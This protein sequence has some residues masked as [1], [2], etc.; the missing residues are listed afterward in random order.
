MEKVNLPS[1]G[2]IYL[3]L[4]FKQTGIMTKAI[5]QR[6]EEKVV[7]SERLTDE[8]AL[9]LFEKA[10]LGF[11]GRLASIS[12]TKI[13]GNKVYFNRNFH[14]EPTNICIHNCLFCSYR[15]RVNQ[16][17][18]WEMDKEAILNE[19]DRFKDRDITEVHIVGGVHPQ[20]DLGYYA[21]IL[22]SI[23]QKRPE[24]HIKAFTA[25]ELDFM[26]RKSKKSFK[27]GLLI[28]KEAGLGSIPGGGAEIF[29]EE[30]RK[31]ICPDKSDS[32]TW[33]EIHQTAHEIGLST[34]A[35]ILYGHLENY[36][37]RI[38]HMK[39]IRNL[40]DKTH[41]FQV[42]IP[43]KY[44]HM[45]NALSAIGEVSVIED[46]KNYAVSRLY[47]DNIPHIK[48]YWP[49]IGKDMAA[50][51]L[52]FGVDDLDGTIDDTTKI[53]SMAGANDQNPSF[54]TDKLLSIIKAAGR[55]AIERDTLYNTIKA[56]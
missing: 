46:L 5:L 26:I 24:L 29:D 9:A 3:F 30:L 56:Y 45:N 39:R 28:L 54:S 47:L 10:E 44:K 25:V 2:R 4:P 43:L 34:N 1:K 22:R 32:K 19:I 53:Y 36:H 50:L 11:L 12:R 52:D 48:A 17:G 38:D 16:E 51:S 27:E 14:L 31:Q 55:Q 7:A 23:K 33:L 6:I 15:R 35:T 20:R 49:M 8:E 21:N 41:G 13:N 37:H 42:F 40:Q 18:A